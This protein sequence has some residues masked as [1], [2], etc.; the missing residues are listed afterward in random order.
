MS[1]NRPHTRKRAVLIS[2]K[3]FLG[4]PEA[5]RPAF[6]RLKEKLDDPDPGKAYPKYFTQ[7]MSFF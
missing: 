7:F 5:L 2:Y 6:P 4:Y 1:S 3:I